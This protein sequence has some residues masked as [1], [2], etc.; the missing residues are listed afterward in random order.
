MK[1]PSFVI[2]CRCSYIFRFFDPACFFY[3]LVTIFSVVAA[4]LVVIIVVDNDE[5]FL[6]LHEIFQYQM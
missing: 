5:A 2:D 4:A 3:M 1:Q 6:R